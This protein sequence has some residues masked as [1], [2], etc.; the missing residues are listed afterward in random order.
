MIM[1]I[2][3]HTI[4]TPESHVHHGRSSASKVARRIQS[5]LRSP[6][7]WGGGRRQLFGRIDT[8]HNNRFKAI[9]G[10]AG[11]HACVHA[12]MYT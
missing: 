2:S 4:A 12:S 11:M 3:N 8:C 1:N 10:Y 5:R 9:N 7:A 6:S